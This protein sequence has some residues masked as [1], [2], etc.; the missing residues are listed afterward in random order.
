[1][2][3][4]QIALQLY[5][6]R[7]HLKTT[8]DFAASMKKVREAGY[9]AVQI[10]GVGEVRNQDIVRILNDEGL[11]CCA[12]HEPSDTILN[13]PQKVVETLQELNCRY[14]AYPY[15]AG[16][17][18][19]NPA[20]VNDLI[21]KLDAAGTVLRENDCVLTYHNHSIEFLR[22]DGKLI[23]D[24]IYD[25]TDPQN[26]SG[27]IDTYWVQHGGGDPADW[28][29]KLTNRLPLL[30]L[31]DYGISEENKQ[32]IMKEIGSG[33]L[34]M[35]EIIRTSEEAG[36]AWFIVEQD[37]CPGDPFD[38]IKISYDYLTTLCED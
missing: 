20:S 6:I 38:S 8:I 5:T 33:N 24:R 3:K 17:D 18:F 13:E 25:E 21:S 30:H 11:T 32:P 2:K 22:I 28:C 23:L 16:I 7:D 26:L 34:N 15:P 12:T 35:P 10:S 1:M 37:T 29:S 9:T 36:C 19:T 31:K 14:T 27:E 4:Q